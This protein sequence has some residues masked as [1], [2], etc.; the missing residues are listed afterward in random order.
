MVI[1]RNVAAV[2]P[3]PGA[4]A[5]QYTISKCPLRG[6]RR[7]AIYHDSFGCR[8]VSDREPAAGERTNT[9][10][11]WLAGLARRIVILVPKVVL[12]QWQNE[13]Y[14]KFNLNV[15][16]YDGQCLTYFALI[17]ECDG[18]TWHVNYSRPSRRIK[19]S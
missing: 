17:I 19:I 3:D 11:A 4:D 2:K 18:G 7:I 12:I 1:L 6:G 13:L 14:E 8:D 9:R 16:I 5:N 10:K 15:P